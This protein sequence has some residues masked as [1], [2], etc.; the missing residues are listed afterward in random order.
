M[1]YAS[2]IENYSVR[3]SHV[4]SEGERVCMCGRSRFQLTIRIFPLTSSSSSSSSPPPLKWHDVSTGLLMVS[5]S[6]SESL[7]P[8]RADHVEHIPPCYLGAEKKRK[9]LINLV[10]RRHVVALRMSG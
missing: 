5:C 10:A 4:L 3:Q 7:A 1:R 2:G 8:V 6:P 9:G